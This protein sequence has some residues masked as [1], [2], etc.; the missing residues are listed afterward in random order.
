M[1]KEE[2]KEYQKEW[3]KKNK[4]KL[5]EKYKNNKEEILENVKKYQKNNKEKIQINS[6]KY[7]ENNK[8]EMKKYNLIYQNKR[9]KEDFLFR[10]NCNLRS[11]IYRVLKFDYNKQNDT[12]KI[13]GCDLYTIKLHLENKFTE[14]MNWDNKG[15]WHIDHIIPL[16]SAKNEKEAYELCHYTNLQPLWAKD[17]LSKGTKIETL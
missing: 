6:K 12:F 10:L 8:K 2:I 1:T 9:R 4:E 15:E 17:N 11:R 5:Q 14:G 3:Y 13:L 16:S 7:Y